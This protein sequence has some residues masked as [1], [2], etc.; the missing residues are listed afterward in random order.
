[1]IQVVVRPNE[2]TAEGINKALKRLKLKVET[3]GIMD[4]VRLHRNFLSTTER[5]KAKTKIKHR[6]AKLARAQSGYSKTK[7]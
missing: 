7:K 5:K 6:K 3:E 4:E 2:Q 1:M